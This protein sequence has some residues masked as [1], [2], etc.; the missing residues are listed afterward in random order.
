M[1]TSCSHRGGGA[2]KLSFKLLAFFAGVL[3][4]LA[5]ATPCVLTEFASADETGTATET[6][7]IQKDDSGYQSLE[8]LYGQEAQDTAKEIALKAFEQVGEDGKVTYE[9]TNNVV[10]ACNDDF[11]DAMSAT[12]LAGA[13]NAPILLTERDTLSSAVSDVISTLGAKNVY[14]IGGVNAVKPDVETALKA[15]SGVENVKRV[16]GY[17]YFDT[18]VK[19]AEEIKT[20]LGDEASSDVIV[21]YGQNF[22]DALSIS[23]F[24]YKYKLPIFLTTPGE[25]SADRGLTN[26]YDTENNKSAADYIKSIVKDGSTI[27]VPGGTGA[28]QM[29]T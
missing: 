14:I 28:V 26:G 22:Q 19:C 17:D 12:G 20:V 15:L 1:Q 2:S 3:F 27:Y 8:R 9:Q 29:L 11:A 4:L 16:A 5:L 18:S 21:A 10:V 6:S 7:N 24:A 13:L 25:G 23:S